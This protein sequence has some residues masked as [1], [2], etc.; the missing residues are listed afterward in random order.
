M[1]S[2]LEFTRIDILLVPCIGLL[3]IIIA[4]LIVTVIVAVIIVPYDE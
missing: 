4:I 3:L 2:K 1:I